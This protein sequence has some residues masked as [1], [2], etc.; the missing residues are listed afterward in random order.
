MY[1]FFLNLWNTAKDERHL[2]Q[3]MMTVYGFLPQTLSLGPTRP[4]RHHN[5]GQGSPSGCRGN[6]AELFFGSGA[7]QHQGAEN[8]V[9]W[10]N[11]RT[12]TSLKTMRVIKK[13]TEKW[14]ETNQIRVFPLLNSICPLIIRLY[15]AKHCVSL[16]RDVLVSH[17]DR[18]LTEA[19]Q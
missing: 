11:S 8:L 17:F 19:E 7:S 18:S 14:T 5:W 2:P 15:E 4:S 1:V 12:E 10:L 13:I 6:T 16:S 9:Y 3:D